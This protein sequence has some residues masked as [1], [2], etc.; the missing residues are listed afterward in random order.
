MEENKVVGEM[1]SL[2]EEWSSTLRMVGNEEET[3]TTKKGAWTEEEDSILVNYVTFHG[4][5]NWNSV[6]RGS[7]KQA[8]YI[9]IYIYI[10]H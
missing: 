10:K 2:S 9:I 6:A 3:E 7:G 1:R 4:E 5:G 8:I